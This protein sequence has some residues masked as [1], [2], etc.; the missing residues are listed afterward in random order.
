MCVCVYI[1][2]H[3]H[4]NLFLA[5]LGFVAAQAFSSCGERGLLSSC[6]A[7]ASHCGSFS[8]QST[9]SRHMGSVVAAPRL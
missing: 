8:L 7:R 6:G 2:I 1:Y 3:T 9:G 5:V 4:I